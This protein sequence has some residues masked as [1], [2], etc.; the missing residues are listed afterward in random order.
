MQVP[1]QN[2]SKPQKDLYELWSRIA[3]NM[4]VS[5]TDDHLRNHGF[6]LKNN[7]WKLYPLY[8]TTFSHFSAVFFCII[9]YTIDIFL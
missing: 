5:N 2:S 8:E 1:K 6:L 7:F 9:V 4:A 3:F